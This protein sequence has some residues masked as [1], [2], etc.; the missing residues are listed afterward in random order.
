[1]ERLSNHLLA[2]RI[3]LGLIT[4][5]HFYHI[6]NIIDTY[7]TFLSLSLY[8]SIRMIH[9]FANIKLTHVSPRRRRGQGSLGFAG[10]ARLR[11]AESTDFFDSG[12]RAER[13]RSV[14][15]L[16]SSLFFWP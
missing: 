13:F 8:I 3:D 5:H 12:E 16:V 7:Y 14:S 2:F 10:A 9:P 11:A 4:Y 15:F 6:F 1:M